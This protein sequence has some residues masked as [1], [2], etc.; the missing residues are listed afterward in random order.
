[1]A[2]TN[3][4]NSNNWIQYFLTIA[5]I[6]TA[7]ITFDYNK[8]T[9]D[10]TEREMKIRLRPV[11]ARLHSIGNKEV[12]GTVDLGFDG[13]SYRFNQEKLSIHFINNGALPANSISY[14]YHIQVLRENEP[15]RDHIKITNSNFL[16]L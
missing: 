11:L 6:A 15:C 14:K 2:I 9:Y 12:L 4:T 7:F 5:V 13:E 16:I 1:V 8:K 3:S 10:Q